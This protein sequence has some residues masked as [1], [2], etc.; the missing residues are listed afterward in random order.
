MRAP[1]TFLGLDLALAAASLCATA[2]LW[3]NP[4]VAYL[5][6]VV[7]IVIATTDLVTHRIPII[8]AVTTLCCILFYAIH[9]H[10]A[11]TMLLAIVALVAV[12]L[13]SLPPFP[14]LRTLT[15][16]DLAA[17]C[18]SATIAPPTIFLTSLLLTILSFF[19]FRLTSRREIRLPLATTLLAPAV[20]GMLVT[21]SAVYR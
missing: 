20:V 13:S 6:L 21:Q 9:L 18:L 15:I 2:L 10:A 7:A 16:A 14:A 3:T 4:T 5:P 11:Q 8:A 17:L 19:A 12:A 1:A